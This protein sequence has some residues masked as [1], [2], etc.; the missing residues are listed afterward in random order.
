VSPVV[1]KDEEEMANV[2][3]GWRWEKAR[4]FSLVLLLAVFCMGAGASAAFA[5]TV[6]QVREVE[7]GTRM[8]SRAEGREIAGL[9][10]QAQQ[11]AVEASDCSHLVNLAYRH[12]GYD[13]PYASSF[14][15]YAGQE[16]FVRVRYPQAGDLVVWP[17]HVGIVM[18]P[19][20]H[21]FFS[22]VSTGMEVQDYKAPY[23]ISRGKRR[24][25]RYK[26]DV[27]GSMTEARVTARQRTRTASQ[28]P[29]LT[30]TT[31]SQTSSSIADPN[32][33]PTPASEK[34]KISDAYSPAVA[35]PAAEKTSFDIPPSIVIA[36]G[37]KQPTSGQVAEA[38]AELSSA[39]G[40]VLRQDDPLKQTMP[41]V[42]FE[43]VRVE[44][45]E[46][47]KDH[48]W[49]KLE[50]DERAT[51]AAGQANYKRHKEKL[52]WEL[53]RTES[54]WEAVT[55]ADK[56]YVPNDVAVRNLAAQLAR[57]T[58]TDGPNA[59]L[60]ATVRQESQIA[61]LLSALLENKNQNQ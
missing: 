5:Q 40:V 37:V 57:L 11:D 42:I 55:P 59:H 47:K 52:R 22:L 3:S 18:S 13:Y 43:R 36:D 4:G 29:N 58:E 34:V 32:R 46:I 26:L 28:Q 20:E 38:I 12:A 9:A 6:K 49:A 50:M 30:A 31:D 39:T 60:D 61:N 41:V 7:P 54:G 53:R 17:G 33:P 14:E 2:T 23:W 35:P 16:N 51:I 10:L 45:L 24:F 44:K 25:Y 15:L 8:L 27:N 1:E 19:S 48:G 21:T 56:T